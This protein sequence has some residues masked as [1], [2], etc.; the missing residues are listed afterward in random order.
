[1]TEIPDR[2]SFLRLAGNVIAIAAVGAAGVRFIDIAEAMPVAPVMEA[3]ERQ[4]A[5]V[6][7][8]QWGP[9]HGPGWR[10]RSRRGRR[11][12]CR[13][14]RGRRHCGWRC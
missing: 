4:P 14:H 13:W 5:L 8:V 9:P 11:W 10:R 6:T 2:R 1:M 3:T 7:P 12:V